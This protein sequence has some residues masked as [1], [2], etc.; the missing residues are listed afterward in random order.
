MRNI[1][2][3][4]CL[5]GTALSTWIWIGGSDVPMGNPAYCDK[6]SSGPEE[7][8]FP[9]SGFGQ[10]AAVGDKKIYMSSG[11]NCKFLCIFLLF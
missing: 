6:G 8:C 1:A 9:P 5:I 10:A 7:M 3:L 11:K 2:L 4:P